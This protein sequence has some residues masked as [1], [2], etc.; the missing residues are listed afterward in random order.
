LRNRIQVAGAANFPGLPLDAFA[1]DDPVAT[2]VV[3]LFANM[4]RSTMLLISSHLEL[5]DFKNLERDII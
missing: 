3:S 2:F 4:A 1:F 5:S